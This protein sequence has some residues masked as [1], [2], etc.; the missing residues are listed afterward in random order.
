ML[1]DHCSM[2]LLNETLSV[3]MVIEISCLVL[4]CELYV[5]MYGSIIKNCLFLPLNSG[6]LVLRI[7]LAVSFAKK[8]LR[9]LWNVQLNQNDHQLQVVTNH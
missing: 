1:K 5:R 4:Q 9:M 8:I 3:H 2:F 6:N 7:G